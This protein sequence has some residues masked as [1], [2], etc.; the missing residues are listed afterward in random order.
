MADQE[1]RGHT[2]DEIVKARLGVDYEKAVEPPE[3]QGTSEVRSGAPQPTQQESAEQTRIEQEARLD[4]RPERDDRL[5][6]AGRGRHTTG[7]I[8]GVS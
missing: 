3:G 2:P 1:T 5:I 7:R 4:G 6:N 8:S